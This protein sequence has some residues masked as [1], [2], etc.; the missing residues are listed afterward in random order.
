MDKRFFEISFR[1]QFFQSVVVLFLSLGCALNFFSEPAFSKTG[2]M[3]YGS[4]KTVLV[5]KDEPGEPL[6]V[7]G[8]VYA[9]DG[10]TPAPGITVYVYHTDAEGYYRK[11]A[12]SSSNPRLKGTMITNGEGKYEFR[13]I[14]PGAYPGGGNPAHIHYVLSGKDYP[15][16]Y[17]EVMFEG[18]PHLGANA[19]ARAKKDGA[20]S[21]VQLLTRDQDGVW[22]CVRD[23][24]LKRN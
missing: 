8:T 11:G 13:T 2:S 23:F 4:W 20:F 15:K 5:S 24:K 17:G 7:S 3:K 19:R 6:I 1:R 22:H 16:Q 21:T 12:T 18:D 10:K 14:K 9:P